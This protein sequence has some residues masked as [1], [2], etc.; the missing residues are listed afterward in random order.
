MSQIDV[1]SLLAQMRSLSRQLQ[2]PETG[3]AANLPG[4]TKT[5]GSNAADSFGNLLKQSIADVSQ[6]Q[7]QAQQASAAFER[8]EPGDDLP[9]VMLAVQKADLSFRAMT[10]VRNKL[11]DAYRDIMNMPM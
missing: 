1:N 9:Q 8:G 2:G 11:V 4:V 3:G 6:L 7:N 5:P 10:E